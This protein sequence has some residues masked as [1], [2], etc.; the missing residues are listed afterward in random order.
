M[1]GEERDIPRSNVGDNWHVPIQRDFALLGI[2]Y[3]P[4]V[5]EK[6]SLPIETYVMKEVGD[7]YFVSRNF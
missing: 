6:L 7:M 1:D 3:K 2:N 4:D 5:C